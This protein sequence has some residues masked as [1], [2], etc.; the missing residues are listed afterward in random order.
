MHVILLNTTNGSAFEMQFSDAKQMHTYLEENS[1]IEYL[2]AN[3]SY[4][5]T[6]HI[7]MQQNSSEV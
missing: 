1:S 5:P 7:R 6:R 4:L 2:S 3:N